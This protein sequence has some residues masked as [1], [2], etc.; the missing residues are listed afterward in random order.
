MNE[1]DSATN[2]LL[3]KSIL[4]RNMTEAQTEEFITNSHV[5]ERLYKRGELIF[6]ET[7]QPK[8]LWLL[9]EGKIAICKDTFSGKRILVT[10]ITQIGDIFGEVYLYMKKPQYEIYAIAEEKSR[11]LSVC[12]DI[13]A[14]KGRQNETQSIFID[15]LLTLFVT[16]AYML[17]MKVRT[18]CSG[19][20]RQRLVH[21]LLER[22][23]A[24]GEIL[25]PMTREAAAE[26]LNVARPSLSREIS[27]LQKEG[28]LEI[29][30]KRI[31]VKQQELLEEYL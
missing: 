27:L 12:P 30:G 14:A 11:V 24:N 16:K 15:N 28:L 31:V 3:R 22:Q 29:H 8:N 18:L 17:Q 23:Q 19:G 10:E 7:E 25:F 13:S 1:K 26:Y 9:V 21:F 20:L 6:R 5:I 4:C 2:A